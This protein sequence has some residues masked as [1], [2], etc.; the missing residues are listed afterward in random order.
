MVSIL[1]IH[2]NHNAGGVFLAQ[3]RVR[4]AQP[5]PDTPCLFCRLSHPPF[6]VVSISNRGCGDALFRKRSWSQR[7]SLCSVALRE[8]WIAPEN[9]ATSAALSFCLR[10][11]HHSHPVR[12][13][14][15]GHR[16]AS[17]SGMAPR[18]PCTPSPW[19][20]IIW[21]PCCYCYLHIIVIHQPPGLM[22]NFTEER[23]SLLSLFPCN[24]ISL[25]LLGDVKP[26]SGRLQSSC[27]VPLLL[28]SDHKQPHSRGSELVWNSWSKN[29][30]TFLEFR[31]YT[32]IAAMWKINK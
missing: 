3:T 32:P 10:F 16:L 11:P 20:L 13:W 19:H 6:T 24:G 30:K 4:I 21:I 18:T 22:R 2:A 7:H 9:S 17:V 31:K 1:K 28:L 27:L 25:S 8:T 26:L 23:R 12:N 5:V 29:A 15:W 14:G